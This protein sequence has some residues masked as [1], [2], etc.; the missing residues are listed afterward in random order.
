MIHRSTS[1]AQQAIKDLLGRDSTLSRS[2]NTTFDA[3]YMYIGHSP[4]Q[5]G[6]LITLGTVVFALRIKVI[7]IN[8][9][10]FIRYL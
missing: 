4:C 10:R 8:L 2:S 7:F 3:Y 5:T 6:I 1:N 9:V